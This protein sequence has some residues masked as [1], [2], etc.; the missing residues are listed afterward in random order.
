MLINCYEVTW[1]TFSKFMHNSYKS[2]VNL[3]NYSRKRH[4]K[5]WMGRGTQYISINTF[6]LYATVCIRHPW[7]VILLLLHI[8][9]QWIT[10]VLK[11]LLSD[12]YL[13]Q[14]SNGMEYIWATSL[15]VVETSLACFPPSLSGHIWKNGNLTDSLYVGYG[16]ILFCK[17]KRQYIC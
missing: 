1:L 6:N 17:L 7:L 11:I 10:T 9:A 3:Y 4:W 14:D 16:F 15:L 13:F 12:Y 8:I 5:D 2:F